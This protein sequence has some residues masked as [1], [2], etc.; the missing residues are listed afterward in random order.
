MVLI[1]PPVV[2]TCTYSNRRRW[3]DVHPASSVRDLGIFIDN[4]LGVATHVRRTVSR[5]FTVP[6]QLRHLRRYVT[7]DCFRSLMVS[8]IHSRLDYE[9]LRPRRVSSLSGAGATTPVRILNAA[10]RLVFRLR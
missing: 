3:R 7:D 5:C 10:A 1:Y 9:N 4:D 2:A 6:R 8:L